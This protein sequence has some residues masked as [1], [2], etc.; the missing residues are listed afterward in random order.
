M[1]VRFVPVYIFYEWKKIS[2]IFIFLV[3]EKKWNLHTCLFLTSVWNRKGNGNNPLYFKNRCMFYR[4]DW[5]QGINCFLDTDRGLKTW[6]FT[7]HVTIYVPKEYKNQKSVSS[8]R[9]RTVPNWEAK[10][11]RRNYLRI[12]LRAI[13]SPPNSDVLMGWEGAGLMDLR[14]AHWSRHGS[15]MS[16]W[17]N[18]L[19]VKIW[20]ITKFDFKRQVGTN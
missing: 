7:K 11:D 2:F 13:H 20:L 10:C 3:A 19:M 9:P 17:G 6:L 18:D 12:V 1:P 16:V 8:V 14:E 4:Y 15:V 5:G